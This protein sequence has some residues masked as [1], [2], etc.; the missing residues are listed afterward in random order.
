MIQ[1]KIIRNKHNNLLERDI[2][3]F[4]TTMYADSYSNGKG[5]TFSIKDIKLNYDN[6]NIL[7]ALII[8]EV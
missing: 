1:V 3:D 7:T 2:N 8:Y 4:I 5:S 6:S